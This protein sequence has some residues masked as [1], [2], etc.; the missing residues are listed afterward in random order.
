MFNTQPLLD[1]EIF[2]SSFSPTS[3]DSSAFSEAVN[4]FYV[5][6]NQSHGNFYY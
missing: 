6:Q 2:G 5:E 3:L 1:K 4:H